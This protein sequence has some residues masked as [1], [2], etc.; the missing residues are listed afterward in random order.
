MYHRIY[1]AIPKMCQIN[2]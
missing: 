1:I 2:C